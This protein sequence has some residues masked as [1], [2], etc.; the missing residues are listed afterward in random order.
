[1]ELLVVIAIIGI[2][3]ALLLPAVQAAREAAR[4]MQCNNNL[5]QIGLAMQ[6]FYSAKKHFPTNGADVGNYT[7]SFPTQDRFER[8]SWLY[9][10]LPFIEETALAQVVP[11]SNPATF[12][13]G[14]VNVPI[15]AYQCP[16]RSDR[17]VS[18]PTGT[19]MV[20]GVCD[21]AI[22]FHHW[23]DVETNWSSPNTPAS[24]LAAG[25]MNILTTQIKS[26]F[27]G[28]IVQGGVCMDSDSACQIYYQ[29]PLITIA[30]VPDGLSKTIVAM[31]KA[32]YAPF[33]QPDPNQMYGCFWD[34]SNGGWT[35][36]S[37]APTMRLIDDY[38]DVTLLADS[39]KYPPEMGAT[40]NGWNNSD[41][42]VQEWGFGSAHNSI[43]NTVWG[44]GSV[45]PISLLLVNDPYNRITN[46]PVG[47]NKYTGA[48]SKPNILLQLS[49]RD[50]GQETDPNSY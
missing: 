30:K 27:K 23:L 7:Y 32:A 13:Q 31:E 14:V 28:V 49:C 3:I 8:A 4:R 15:A 2:L 19:G 41:G 1:V 24:Y 37:C 50:D 21:Y 35:A 17:S 11:S 43:I 33:Y 45:R 5:K 22:P 42:T 36:P 16:S 18:K 9:Q 12:G 47:N 26:Y 29:L 48:P 39:Q 34:I 40:S 38:G 6:N 10:I 25:G 46:Q 20:Y 44:D